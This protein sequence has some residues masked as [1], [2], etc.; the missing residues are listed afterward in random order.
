MTHQLADPAAWAGTDP[1]AQPAAAILAAGERITA[2][3]T[4]IIRHLD[5][6]LPGQGPSTLAP[7]QVHVDEPWPQ[8]PFRQALARTGRQALAP[9]EDLPAPDDKAARI[10][11]DAAAFYSAQADGQLGACLPCLTRHQPPDGRELADRVRPRRMDHAHRAPADGRIHRRGDRGGRARPPLL[12]RNPH[13]PLPRPGHAARPQRAT[14]RSPDSPAAP[15]PATRPAVPKYLNSPQTSLY[16]KGDL[17]FGLRQAR[18]PLAAGAIPVIVEG[19]FDAIAVTIAG[20][21]GHAGLAPCGTAL[22]ARQAALLARPATWPAPERSSH[23][24]PTRPA[25]GRHPRLQHPPPV[26]RHPPGGRARRPRPGPDPGRKRR[27]YATRHP[28]RPDPAAA[29]RHRRCRGQP[30]G[31]PAGR[32]GRTVP[33]DA[34]RRHGPRRTA[35]RRRS[36]ADNADHRGRRARRSRRPDASR[37]LPAAAGD[38]PHPPG[39]YR[40]R[41]NAAS[42]A[43]SASRHRTSSSRS[44]TP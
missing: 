28:H 42:R 26:H 12:A 14:A 22:T 17:L 16:R 3:T 11:D 18:D 44:P 41:D 34:R 7:G 21:G 35:A 25:D 32:R 30:A 33:R 40:Q 9:A 15:A 27:R 6:T 36:H 19:P 4:Q 39:R 38:R 2:A 43:G 29:R 8:A 23:S 20:D 5:R 13:R 10:L 31:V 24:T 37:R 1:R